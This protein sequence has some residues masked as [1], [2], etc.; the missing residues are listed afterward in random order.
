MPHMQKG[1]TYLL[2]HGPH[3]EV[4]TEMGMYRESNGTFVDLC[5]APADWKVSTLLHALYT[6]HSLYILLIN[7]KI[8]ISANV[9][10]LEGIH[11][12]AFD[13]VIHDTHH[14]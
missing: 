10:K 13:L 8:K 2:F 14:L 1:P 4:G 3:K 6:N 9:L 5:V 12:N 7:V 11:S